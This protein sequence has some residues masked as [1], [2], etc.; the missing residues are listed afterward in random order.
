MDL[1]TAKARRDYRFVLNA[2][3]EGSVVLED[4]RNGVMTYLTERSEPFIA[5]AMLEIG[6]LDIELNIFSEAQVTT[7]PEKKDDLS[8]VLDY[9]VCVKDK[10]GDWV[11]DG[12]L[13]YPV[14]VDFKSTDWQEQLE[15]DMFGV[16]DRYAKEKG[17]SYDG[18][19]EPAGVLAKLKPHQ[20][21]EDGY[22][23]C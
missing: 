13:E 20:R 22:L 19:N 3:D 9:F 8:P 2:L 12:Y 7:L 6:Y 15:Q 11:N 4:L 14:A 16:L 5:A 10:H 1:E 23:E 21:M 18:P 17:Y